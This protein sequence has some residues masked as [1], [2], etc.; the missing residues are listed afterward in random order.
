MLYRIIDWLVDRAMKTPYTH[1]PGYMMRYWLVPF[2]PGGSSDN[3]GNATT[4][5]A[6][7][8]Q[9][10]TWL[11]QRLG[12]AVR[13]HMI[14]SSDDDR[15]FHD[16]PWPFLSII[17]EGGYT[18]VRPVFDK[19]GLYVGDKRQKFGPGSIIVRRAKDWHRIEI[20]AF[21]RPTTLFITGPYVQKWGFLAHPKHKV[22][23][24]EHFNA[25]TQE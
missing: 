6:T 9:P 4:W 14:L 19:S 21:P 17:L 16:H 13:V 15:A 1:L 23:Y 25:R 3:K 18:E 12:I 11:L 8:R 20:G 2:L 24:Y 10:L 5:R 22:P 7:W